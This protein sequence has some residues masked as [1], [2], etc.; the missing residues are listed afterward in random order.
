[1]HR[2]LG[3]LQGKLGIVVLGVTVDIDE[4]I[5]AAID[6]SRTEEVI[7]INYAGLSAYLWEALGKGQSY[8]DAIE[9]MFFK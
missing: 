9:R 7:E 3:R 2:V 1:M 6:R 4:K 8:D 5:R